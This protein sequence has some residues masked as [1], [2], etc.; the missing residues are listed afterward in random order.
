MKTLIMQK[1]DK[2]RKKTVAVRKLE[3]KPQL[4]LLIVWP[5]ANH[6]ALWAPVCPVS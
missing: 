5:W 3:P 2:H 6:P 4:W 1:L